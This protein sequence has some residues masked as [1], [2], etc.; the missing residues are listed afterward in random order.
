M[1]VLDDIGFPAFPPTGGTFSSGV[2]V[3]SPAP[4]EE[5]GMLSKLAE[6]LSRPGKAVSEGL[7]AA[8]EGEDPL[9]AAFGGLWSG[10]TEYPT[11]GEQLIKDSPD[12]DY[13]EK[14]FKPIAREAINWAADPLMYISAG[15]VRKAIGLGIKGASKVLGKI[16]IPQV[17]ARH[18]IPMTFVFKKW[19]AQAGSKIARGLE[20]GYNNHSVEAGRHEADLLEYLAEIGLRS[21]KTTPH[22]NAA[23]DLLRGAEATTDVHLDPKT[24]SLYRWLQAKLDEV[25]GRVGTYKDKTGRKFKTIEPL[26]SDAKLSINKQMRKWKG[27]LSRKQESWREDVWET[28]LKGEGPSK[29]VRSQKLYSLLDKHLGKLKL[30]VGHVSPWKKGFHERPWQ[31]LEGY[32]PYMLNNKAMEMLFKDKIP[33][34]YSKAVKRFAKE[35]GVQEEKAL[36]IL[37]S[38]A[39][40]KRAGNI[41]FARHLPFSK[42][43]FETDPLLWFPKYMSKLE[44]R[45]AYA[46]EFGLDGQVLKSLYGTMR[47]DKKATIDMKWAK[48]AQNIILGENPTDRSISGLA[49]KI[50]G[51]QVMTKMGYLSTLSNLS[52]NANPIIREGGTNFLKG[53]LRSMTKEGR[54]QGYIAYSKGMEAQLMRLAG[55][56]SRAAT[57]YLDW[58]LFNPTERLNRMLSSNAGIVRAEQLIKRELTLGGTGRRTAELAKRGAT[59]DD[60]LKFKELGK[61]PDESAELV[62]FLASEAT[63]HATHWKDLP[64]GWQDPM[65]RIMTQYKNFTF[66]QTRFLLRDILKPAKLYFE[67]NGKE[68]SIAPLARAGVV[69]GLSAEFVGQARSNIKGWGARLPELWGSEPL[70]FKERERREDWALQLLEDSLN[71]GA[72]GI[73]G[74]LVDRASWRDL[75]GWMLGPTFGDATSFLEETAIAAGQLHKQRDLGALPYERYIAQLA[76]RTPGFAGV[77]PGTK[78]MTELVGPPVGSVLE[79]IGLR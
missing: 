53:I 51:F 37:Q 30:E 6:L 12:D 33:G 49:Q 20:R 34:D 2:G 73:A 36:D 68:G 64:I 5:D 35:L 52:Q 46:D 60:I 9:A 4:E 61:L 76:R 29:S 32:A 57:R 40:P 1:G 62:G 41:E 54:R 27:A 45:I 18:A 19:G 22:R 23:M 24:Q 7:G 58:T 42:E 71:V 25:A 69:F 74:D 78:G 39:S 72:L 65:M 79:E 67:S 21:G 15:P 8:A 28:F 56:R 63:Q 11:L 47:R 44:E 26:L 38:M 13:E 50:M 48:D 66:Q 77:T 59:N 55:A 17:L 3:G 70:A 10:A 16:P 14:M 31:K 43:L 75:S